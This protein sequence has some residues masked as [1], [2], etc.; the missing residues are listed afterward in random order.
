VVDTSDDGQATLP[1]NLYVGAN[2]PMLDPDL[3]NH[4][5]V[6]YILGFYPGVVSLAGYPAGR[7][8][9]FCLVPV[10]LEAVIIMPVWRAV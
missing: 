8:T 7:V 4:V 1:S 6:R 2:I 9:F 10:R 5:G 3:G